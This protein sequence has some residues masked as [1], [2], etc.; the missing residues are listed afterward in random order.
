M[1]TINLMILVAALIWSLM[2]TVCE[3]SRH[4]VGKRDGLDAA[5]AFQTYMLHLLVERR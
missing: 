4:G 2:L 3:D 1:G 5:S